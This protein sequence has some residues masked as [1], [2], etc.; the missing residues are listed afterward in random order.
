M[1]LSLRLSLHGANQSLRRNVSLEALI[2]TKLVAPILKEA[3][4]RF[5]Y[6]GCT[7]VAKMTA[8]GPYIITAWCNTESSH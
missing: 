7:I 3:P 4:L 6:C 1:S 2:G 5:K 8:E